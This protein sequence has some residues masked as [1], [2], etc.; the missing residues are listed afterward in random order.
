VASKRT[1]DDAVAA[2]ERAGVLLVFPLQN[3]PDPPSLWRVLHPRSEMRWAWDSG[4]D[5]RVVEL[6]HLREELAR[7]RRVVYSKWLGGRATFF[8]RA[9]FRALLADLRGI[10]ELRAGLGTD[11]R[12]ILEVLDDDSPRPTR[13]LRE[14]SGLAGRMLESA[15]TQAM[16]PLWTRLLVVGAGETPE[17][18]FPSLEIGATHLLFEDLWCESPGEDDPARIVRAAASPAFARALRRARASLETRA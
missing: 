12:A 13:A 7:S 10:S 8:S 6:W 5:R 14:E 18:G 11:A 1:L 2:I 4:A 3:K 17:G 16:R 15:W 9:L